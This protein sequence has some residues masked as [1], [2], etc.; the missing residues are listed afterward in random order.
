MSK[1]EDILYIAHYEGIRDEV[2]I[3]SKKRRKEEQKW[4]HAEYSDSIEEAYRRV[5]ERNNLLK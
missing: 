4:K 3:E 1:I 2:L 5:K